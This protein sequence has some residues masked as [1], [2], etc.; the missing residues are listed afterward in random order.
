MTKKRFQIWY[1]LIPA[2]IVAAMFLVLM[3]GRQAAPGSDL[4][5]ILMFLLILGV[6]AFAGF[7]TYRSRKR[8]AQSGDPDQIETGD[9][10]VAG[11]GE[12]QNH[13]RWASIQ[14]FDPKAVQKMTYDEKNDKD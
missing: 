14:Y 9:A 10:N 1:V 6:I 11:F 12:F 8:K 4:T 2:M 7:S 3:I 13:G 5:A